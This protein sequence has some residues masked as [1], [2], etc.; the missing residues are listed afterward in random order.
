VAAAVGDDEE[1][2]VVEECGGRAVEWGVV[3]AA[4]VVGSGEFGDGCGD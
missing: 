4:G 3:G 2:D 1:E